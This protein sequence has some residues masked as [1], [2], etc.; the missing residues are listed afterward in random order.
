MGKFVKGIVDRGSKFYG[1]RVLA[2]GE[3]ISYADMMKQWS[4]GN[5]YPSSYIASAEQI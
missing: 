3:H 5:S 1:K 4:Q 2:A